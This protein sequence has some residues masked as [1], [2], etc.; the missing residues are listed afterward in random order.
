MIK[1]NSI[2][3]RSDCPESSSFEGDVEIRISNFISHLAILAIFTLLFAV[4]VHSAG[5]REKAEHLLDK[6]GNTDSESERLFY[7]RQLKKIITL[8]PNLIPHLNLPDIKKLLHDISLWA[9]LKDCK[10]I[11]GARAGRKGYLNCF[12]FDDSYPHEISKT[13]PLYPIMCLYR[14]RVLVWFGVEKR[15]DRQNKTL[16]SQA[17]ECFEEVRKTFPENRIAGMYLGERLFWPHKYDFHPKAPEWANLQRKAIEGLTDIIHWWIRERMLKDGQF[18]GGW[19]DDC[20]MWRWW[21]PIM[22]AFD[23][24]EITKAQAFFS[25]ALLSQKHMKRGYSS[26]SS[27]VEHSAEDTADTITPMLHLR[28]EK[29]FWQRK[30]MSAA[31]LMESRWT[32]KNKRGFL[33][34][35]N[36]Y[37][38]QPANHRKKKNYA[39]DTVYHI[40]V[41]QPALL[42]WQQ[43]RDKKLGKLFTA[44]MDTWTESAMGRSRGKPAGILP[45]V[46]HWPDG[47]SSGDKSSK[48]WWNPAPG[49]KKLYNWPSGMQMMTD[50]LLLSYHMT[51]RGKYLSPIH[52]M[53]KMYQA[54]LKNPIRNPRKGSLE[55]CASKMRFLVPTL[56]KY[57]FL[58]GDHRYDDILRQSRGY[59]EFLITGNKNAVAESLRET[60]KALSQNFE[61]FTSEV[62]FTDRVLKLPKK[63][64]RPMNLPGRE[65]PDTDFLFS[66]LTGEPGRLAYFPMNAVRWL[67]SS[68]DIAALVTQSSQNHFSAELFHFGSAPRKMRAELYLLKPGTYKIIL[69]E[70]GKKDKK[71]QLRRKIQITAPRTQVQFQLP[72]QQLC[73]L[74]VRKVRSGK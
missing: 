9:E 69:R 15:K 48:R 34:F 24:P 31:K 47:Y 8:K 63:W 60:A 35:R 72:P 57:R 43:T 49:G 59:G 5:M 39:F 62:R 73:V 14:A 38:D 4:T 68:R 50:T 45:P 46:I 29:T 67:T 30:A 53:A 64:F 61:G 21:I 40:R 27:D 11:E 42:L 58:T 66:T 51:G 1:I 3:S 2:F 13:S 16:F 52:S 32:G 70:K 25:N 55:W 23:D 26:R 37:L 54:Y 44:W 10:D 18:G 36:I 6:A 19:G 71:K 56:A 33:Q 74:E 28:P 12:L 7:L 41:V 17:S 22:I 20:E 65:M